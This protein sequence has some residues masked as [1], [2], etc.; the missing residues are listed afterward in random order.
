MGSASLFFS[1]NPSKALLSD[2]NDEL[3]H[4]F[5]MVRDEPKR[6]HQAL[7]SLPLGKDFYYEVRA[8]NPT[9]LSSINRAARFIYLNRFC[10]NGI[11]RTNRKGEFNVPYA[12]SGTGGLPTLELLQSAAVQLKKCTLR[13]GDFE[14]ILLKEVRENDFVYMDPPYAVSTRRVFREYGPQPFEF[15]DVNRLDRLLDEL[16]Q[17]KAKFVVSYAMTNEIC[18]VFRRWEIKRVV[19]QRNVSGFARHRRKAVELLVTNI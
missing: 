17:R 19:T 11:Y 6:V 1:L 10:F 3:V 9:K 12:A 8:K 18:R 15:E 13:C 7:V 14:S 16:D 4:A 2:L 5:C